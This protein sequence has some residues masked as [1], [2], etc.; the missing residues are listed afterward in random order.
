MSKLF[1]A[2]FGVG[3]KNVAGSMRLQNQ[4]RGVIAW[5]ACFAFGYL[6]VVRIADK[7]DQEAVEMT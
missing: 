4:A 7:I 6:E 5:L 1:V 3:Y 2:L